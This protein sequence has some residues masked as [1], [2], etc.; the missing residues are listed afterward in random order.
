MGGG[1]LGGF[2]GGGVRVGLWWFLDEV[3]IPLLGTKVV[4][5]AL[6]HGVEF[7]QPPGN[8]YE[9]SR[10]LTFSM[11]S[12]CRHQF[13]SAWYAFLKIISAAALSRAA[14]DFFRRENL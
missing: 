4:M 2:G 1:G 14:G 8:F 12:R 11:R 5:I 7:C 3:S 6:C 13:G 10:K 9:N